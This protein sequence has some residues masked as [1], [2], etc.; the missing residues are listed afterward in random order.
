MADEQG[1]QEQDGE[2]S[3]NERKPRNLMGSA[4]RSVLRSATEWTTS[5]PESLLEWLSESGLDPSSIG[6]RRRSRFRKE[7]HAGLCGHTNR[8]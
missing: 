3:G 6:L 7:L 5:E 8:A 1:S 4:S 2:E